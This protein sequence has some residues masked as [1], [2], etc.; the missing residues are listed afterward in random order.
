[1]LI[2]NAR[3][4]SLARWTLASALLLFGSLGF[5]IFGE[6]FFGD[7]PIV[8]NIVGPAMGLG[9]LGFM[10]F[11]ILLIEGFGSNKALWAR[12]CRVGLALL[13]VMWTSLLLLEAGMSLDGF[14]PGSIDRYMLGPLAGIFILMVVLAWLGFRRSRISH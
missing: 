9:Q 14:E 5:E 6:S 2:W 8:A 7:H 13:F 4:R 10:V 1:M 11:T 12:A 3:T